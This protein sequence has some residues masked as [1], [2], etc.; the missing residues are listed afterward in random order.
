M[1]TW[2][3]QILNN[4]YWH[5]DAR[6][7]KHWVYTFCQQ[8]IKT[9][10]ILT[11][12]QT[13]CNCS[14]FHFVLQRSHLCAVNTLRS[15]CILPSNRSIIAVE[16]CVNAM[17]SYIS[18]QV[19]VRLRCSFAPIATLKNHLNHEEESQLNTRF[20]YLVKV[21]N[22]Q[23]CSVPIPQLFVNLTVIIQQFTFRCSICFKLHEISNTRRE[24]KVCVLLDKILN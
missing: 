14:K 24:E 5:W 19:Q 12:A 22:L 10:R 1:L 21:V 7:R 16:I 18:W 20:F 6:R 17:H 3:K 15:H 8:H 11:L 23:Q 2:S 4:I 9:A 13:R